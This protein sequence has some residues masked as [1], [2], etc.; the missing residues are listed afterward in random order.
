MPVIHY[1]N[2][3][4]VAPFE[5]D[6]S[7]A[8]A[9]I[10]AGTIIPY[11]GTGSNGGIGPGLVVSS[12]NKLL[13]FGEGFLVNNDTIIVNIGTSGATIP[14]L[15]GTNTWNAA[16][17]F[18][19]ITAADADGAN[20]TANAS[21]HTLAQW[22]QGAPSV[23]GTAAGA[24]TGTSGATVPLLNGVNTWSG[25]QGFGSNQVSGSNFSITGGTIGGTVTASGANVT[26]TGGSAKTL[27][28]W[29]QN[30]PSAWG[31]ASGINTGT[32]GATIPLLNGA[33]TWSAAQAFG[34]N[35]VGGSNFSI[36]GGTLSGTLAGNPTWSG[37]HIFNGA[38]TFNGAN[39][40]ANGHSFNFADASGNNSGFLPSG[41][42][43]LFRGTTS[44]GTALTAFT[45]PLHVDSPTLTFSI[46]VTTQQPTNLNASPTWSGSG[47]F[48]AIAS[49]QVHTGSTTFAGGGA[50]N[51]LSL[52]D[53]VA[54]A[55]THT[56]G[57]LV[58]TH[59]W[60]GAAVGSRH[61]ILSVLTLT[62]TS[63]NGA[64][65]NS[66]TGVAG[67]FV[68]QAQANDGGVAG[69]LKGSVFGTNP[70]ATL[71]S[72]ATFFQD[73][74]GTEINFGLQTGSSAGRK[75]GLQIV[76]RND[77]AVNAL[78]PA[79]ECLLLLG[80]QVGASVGIPYAL[81]IGDHEGQWP[82]SANGSLISS[83]IGQSYPAHPSTVKWGVDFLAATFPSTGNPYDGGYLRSTNFSVDGAGTMQIG[84]AYTSF[85]ASG[86]AIDLKGSVGTGTPAVVGIGTG[87]LDQTVAT[88][89]YGGIYLIRAT[90]GAVTSLTVYR[91][92]SYKN[93][94]TPSNPVTLA[95]Y[96]PMVGIASGLT[97]NLAWNTT[98]STLSL[99]PSGGAVKLG[100]G[101][102]SANG[103]VATL[104]TS[105]GPT[106]SHTTVQE[107]F[108]ITNASGVV[109]YIPAF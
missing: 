78:G 102:F 50:L 94:T 40:V 104:L 90:A 61:G 13:V 14:L 63:G 18:G 56:L 33:N 89:P 20:V 64:L 24:N 5:G 11:P 101:A 43:L 48:P 25:A 100:A 68:A 91:Q 106:G 44:T 22:F 103:S 28:D 80:S 67:T 105:L 23:W 99:Q 65:G 12:P 108:T 16:Q 3:N 47:L 62:T 109:R 21:T 69:T 58:I 81:L 26:A 93:T 95:P 85:S 35:Q 98:A 83:S 42:N 96:G 77:D 84:T 4:P 6:S 9:S 79:P 52:T 10:D 72:G 76:Q 54:A 53:H 51:S 8:G 107:W 88:D 45:L 55:P 36:S 41:N 30:A 49:A 75:V 97:V 66:G 86:V 29:F 31:T 82:M 73:C 34:A 46:P 60:G 87:W 7:V 32:S 1:P 38:V 19:V 37:S 59:D 15:S 70:V 92:P 71:A 39:V 74:V 27:G 17:A 2:D 57:G